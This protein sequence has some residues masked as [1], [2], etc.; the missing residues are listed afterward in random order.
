MT[1]QLRTL[2]SRQSR[3]Q[4]TLHDVADI[5]NLRRAW[6]WLRTDME[7]AY[8]KD[9][10][11]NVDYRY[12]LEKNLDDLSV[13]LKEHR[14][15][16]QRTT[17]VEVVKPSYTTRPISFPTLEDRLVAWAILAQAGPVL[18][19]KI[20]D[21][22][23]AFRIREPPTKK[24]FFKSWYREWPNFIRY[25]RDALGD[26]FPCLLR[27]DIAGYFENIDLARLKEMILFTGEIHE[28]VIELLFQQLELWVWHFFYSSAGQRGLLQGDDFSSLYANFF[29]SEIDDWLSDQSDLV[30]YRFMD[31]IVIL[32]HHEAGAKGA[33]ALLCKALRNKTLTI[34]TAKTFILTGTQIEDHFHFTLWDRLE[35]LL[36]RL[37]KE[38]PSQAV[39][40]HARRIYR[41]ILEGPGVGSSHFRR[42][43]T[44]LKRMRDPFLW[45]DCLGYLV[46][47]TA[48]TDKI[49][50]YALALP[51]PMLVYQDLV[52]F[53][54]DRAR[55]VYPSQEQMIIETL[56][57]LDLS[58]ASAMRPF[59][60]FCR[61]RVHDSKTHYYSASLYAL[62]IYKYGQMRDL[63]ALN[64][65]FHS[66]HVTHPLLLKHLALCSTR[67]SRDRIMKARDTLIAHVDPELTR[68]G[69]FIQEV[70][71]LDST[72]SLRKMVRPSTRVFG[73]AKLVDLDIRHLI[74]LN[75]L[76]L[77]QHEKNNRELLDQVRT[78]RKTISYRRTR[79]LLN[80]TIMDIER[81]L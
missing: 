19:R 2:F 58:G 8:I 11:F 1:I 3:V 56:L 18:D 10:T 60:R 23:M 27:T 69:L 25:V 37:K 81:H 68:L 50:E 65:L 31:D 46:T 44:A 33:L 41:L 74:L 61:D 80:E 63:R 16:P 12:S 38:E 64:K 28:D 54:Q 76:K 51:D 52:S 22:S 30:Y 45:H 7:D 47:H 49:M 6:N 67:L 43:L 4:V 59:L 66:G 39:K 71:A 21:V 26:E 29:L 15:R 20:P 5:D 72:R 32:A 24:K 78:L 73:R 42:F 48:Q 14:Y 13:R 9:P 53:L 57:Q 35:S 70:T 34:N 77:N 40:R 55:N 36:D 17:I 75:L 79:R 62:F